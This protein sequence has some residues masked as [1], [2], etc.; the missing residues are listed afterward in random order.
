[1]KARDF[2]SKR[3]LKLN[4]YFEVQRYE[5][6]IGKKVI[7]NPVDEGFEQEVFEIVGLMYP[8]YSTMIHCVL[9]S[10]EC[11]LVIF[12]GIDK[13]GKKKETCFYNPGYELL[14]E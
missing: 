13:I 1:M 12:V 10:L 4:E 8:S 9:R 6:L 7:A 3:R 11:G 2:Y 5:H 14:L